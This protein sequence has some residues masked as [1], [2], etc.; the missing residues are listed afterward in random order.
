[1]KV[2]LRYYTDNF[3]FR[4]SLNSIQ[5]ENFPSK[6][7]VIWK[8]ISINLVLELSSWHNIGI[9]R[10]AVFQ[11]GAGSV[12]SHLPMGQ[13]LHVFRSKNSHLSHHPHCPCDLSRE[14]YMFHLKR[15]DWLPIA[16]HGFNKGSQSTVL[17][18]GSV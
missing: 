6:K 1:M 3:I 8:T 18:R 5:S 10:K 15:R 9:K 16:P 12:S 2:L 17:H 4:K 14:K 11:N 13:L 7:N